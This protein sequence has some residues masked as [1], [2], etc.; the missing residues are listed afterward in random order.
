MPKTS[1]AV[2]FK[3]AK[4]KL[5]VTNYKT[6]LIYLTTSYSRKK[7]FLIFFSTKVLQC[8]I[9]TSLFSLF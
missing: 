1:F 6:L 2:T 8:F 9:P 4:L 5:F 7:K 3:R